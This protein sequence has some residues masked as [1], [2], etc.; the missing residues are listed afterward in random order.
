VALAGVFIGT[1]TQFSPTYG[2]LVLIFAFE[3][4]IIGGLGSLWGTL[5]GGLVLGCAQTI[6]AQI[7]PASGILAGHLVFLAVLL[8]RPSGLMP[9]VVAA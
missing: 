9:K 4:V 8:V 6:G 5:L 2:D 3:A 1:T 7:D